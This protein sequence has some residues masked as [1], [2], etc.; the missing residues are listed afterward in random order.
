MVEIIKE[1]KIILLLKLLGDYN[2]IVL[3]NIRE[4]I[5]LLLKL[6]GDYN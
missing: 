6:L 1:G 4:C 3:S 5:I 2:N